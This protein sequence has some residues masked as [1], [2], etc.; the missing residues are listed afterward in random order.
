MPRPKLFRVRVRWPIPL[1]AVNVAPVF[2]SQ[3]QVNR[4]AVAPS[5]IVLHFLSGAYR[6]VVGPS[7]VDMLL[8]PFH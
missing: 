5:K 1:R 7:L 2:L 4:F 3:N 6:R 8:K